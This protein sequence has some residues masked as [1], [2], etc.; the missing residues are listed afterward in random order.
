MT[1]GR[2]IYTMTFDHYQEVPKSV[3]DEIVRKR[4]S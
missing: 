1:Q 2:G 3:A 4:N